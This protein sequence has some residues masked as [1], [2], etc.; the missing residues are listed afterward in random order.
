MPEIIIDYSYWWFLLFAFVAIVYSFILY[1]KD[2]NL[3]EIKKT[4]VYIL[5]LLRFT[6]VFILL[7][8]LLNPL[9]KS[10]K[11]NTEKPII[12]ILQDNSSS[13]I[14]NKDSA[15]YKKDYLE[16]LHKLK[17]TLNNNYETVLYTFGSK[18]EKN[19]K[20][21]FNETKT[22]IV[23]ALNKIKDLYINRNLGAIILAS[24]GI[25]NSG[26]NPEFYKS[27]SK[28][29]IYT[30]LMGDTTNYKDVAIKN[31]EFNKDVFLGNNFPI[32]VSLKSTKIKNERAN[33]FI[34]NK[35]QIIE[36]KEV[37]LTE[38]NLISF[39]L[40]AKTKGLVRYK[41]TVESAN[42]K[43]N[44]K[45]NN[46]TEIVVNVIDSKKKILMLANSPHPD[47]FAIK[48]ALENNTFYKID[49][50]IFS[51]NTINIKD[52][53]LIIF[54]QLP[55]INNN[56]NLII[57]QANKLNI[58][59]M[60]IVGAQTS[61]SKFNELNQN[62]FVETQNKS[63]EETTPE[64]NKNFTLFTQNEYFEDYIKEL[65]PLISNFA[66][67]KIGAK[68]E[69]LF[70]QKIRNIAT[71][72]PLFVLIDNNNWR[73]AF[74]SG[75][76]IWKWKL[77][78][79]KQNDSFENFNTLINKTIQYLTA[80]NKNNPLNVEFNKVYNTGEE[81]VF[82]A[83]FLNKSFELIN[84]PDL[85]MKIENEKKE[86]FSYGFD[87]INDKYILKIN[88]INGGDYKFKATLNYAQTDYSFSGNFSVIDKNIE[89]LNLV[90]NHKILQNI[91]TNSNAKYFYTN[92]LANIDDELKQ[93]NTISKIN[94]Y[95]SVLTELVN[96]IWV[97]WLIIA[98][99]SI[100]WF[101]RKYS[102]SY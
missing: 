99:I 29:P 37:V 89:N 1:R 16:N 46:Q 35:G 57:E 20:I 43:E 27:V 47:V 90:A 91:A 66:N 92:E 76:G 39:K 83:Q 49:F 61:I 95:Q 33:I 72:R 50:S 4:I 87:K 36:K 84:S 53:D 18:A 51:N 59:T 48:S 12:V 93:N 85:Y 24:D 98:I 11:K 96:N 40:T 34:E 31:V 44:N 32:D 70:N 5:K 22:N 68:H 69:V 102:G 75:E 56:I 17:Q 30:I 79:F 9:F 67:Y 41:I 15:F 52:Y 6:V 80:N 77:L 88:N 21:N 28:I 8:L 97:F 94:Y 25:Y 54:H 10:N 42:I 63:F 26:A 86:Q 74:I 73:S 71:D 81:I 82:N 3:S 38:N 58:S 100:E 13:V 62:I 23:S 7:T 65:T 64:L 78:D 60:F 14:Y 101:I 2:K 19:E 45:A 55:S